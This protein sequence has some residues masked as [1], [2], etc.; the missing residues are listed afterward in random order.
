MALAN[1]ICENAIFGSDLMSEFERVFII[2]CH[3]VPA[4]AH[5]EAFVKA[6]CD[7]SCKGCHGSDVGIQHVLL[8]FSFEG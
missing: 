3:W 2:F 7:G 1:G 5:R 8:Q 6:S 4:T